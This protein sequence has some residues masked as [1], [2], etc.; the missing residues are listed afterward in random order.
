MPDNRGAARTMAG[1][2]LE[3]QQTT[4]VAEQHLAVV[5]QRDAASRAPEQR[6]FGFKLQSLDPL[7]DGRL[8]QVEPFGG[9]VKTAAIG[10]GDKGAQQV[11]VEHR[12]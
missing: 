2:L 3:L 6:A 4:S 8:R 12:D 1:R 9:T 5:G 7:A 10:N 11:E